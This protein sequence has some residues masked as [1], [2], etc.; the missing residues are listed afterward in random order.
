M[1]GKYPSNVGMQHYVILNGEPWGLGLDEKILP[2]YMKE[3][4]Y[5]THLIG[6]WHLGFHQKKY[7][8]CMRGY[9]THLGYYSGLIDYYNHSVRSEV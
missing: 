1:T 2:Q 4:G 6:K 3:A 7:T 9:D 5:S 8:P